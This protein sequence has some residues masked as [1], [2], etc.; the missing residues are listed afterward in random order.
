MLSR[1][2]ENGTAARFHGTITWGPELSPVLTEV[3][4]T[5]TRGQL[6]AIV[7]ATG[8]GKTAL[9]YALLGLTDAVPGNRVRIQGSC[10]FVAQQAFIFGGVP[11]VL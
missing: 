11:L 4:F 10:A 6:V 3:Q 5:A 7:G 1:P 9:L 2:L 8:S